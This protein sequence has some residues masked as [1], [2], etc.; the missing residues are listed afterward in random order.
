V[1]PEPFDRLAKAAAGADHL[2]LTRR[3]AVKLTA[4]APVATAPFGARSATA[5]APAGAA[6]V[7]NE[8][9]LDCKER[10]ARAYS[11]NRQH[12]LTLT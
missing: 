3:T 7:P 6:Q 5:A 2:P 4:L 10:V 9:C 1:S 8:A 12:C 11:R